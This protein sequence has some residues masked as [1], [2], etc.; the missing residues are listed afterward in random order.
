MGGNTPPLRTEHGWLT[1]YHGVGEDK[2]YR[3]GALLL[4]LQDP[5]RVLCRTRDWI[6][7]PEEDYEINGPYKA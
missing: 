2:Q 3:L 7:Q 5:T 6:M 1:I 4:D